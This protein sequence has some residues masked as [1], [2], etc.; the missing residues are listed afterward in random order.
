MDENNLLTMFYC[1]KSNSSFKVKKTHQWGTTNGPHW[2]GRILQGSLFDSKVPSWPKR[3]RFCLCRGPK[4]NECPAKNYLAIENLGQKIV[5]R[6]SQWR[7]GGIGLGQL[8]SE[9]RFLNIFS[10]NWDTI[11][12]S[13]TSFQMS[14]VC[15][16]LFQNLRI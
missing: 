5:T 4:S 12:E 9:A 6:D 11:W 7:I 14:L 3:V 10:M 13:Y 2:L 1:K 8:F 15:H 16:E